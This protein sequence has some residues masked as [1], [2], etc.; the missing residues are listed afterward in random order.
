MADRVLDEVDIECQSEGW[1]FNTERAVKYSPS[2]VDGTIFLGENILSIDDTPYRREN[3]DVDL[4]HRGDYLYDGETNGITFTKDVICDL[5]RRL[6]WEQLPEPFKR[7]VT[8]R[9]AR[10]F[11]DTMVADHGTHLYKEADERKAF[12]VARQRDSGQRDVVLSDLPAVD[13]RTSVLGQGRIRH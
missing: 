5:I 2:P 8:I 3:L 4:S 11:A 6:D 1:K 13:A 9:A 7:Y 10:R 12:R